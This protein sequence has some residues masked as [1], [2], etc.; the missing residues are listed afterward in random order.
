MKALPIVFLFCFLSILENWNVEG[1]KGMKIKC[2][3]L[4]RG[5]FG[6]RYIKLIINPMFLRSTDVISR[7]Y[8]CNPGTRCFFC[9]FLIAFHLGNWNPDS[10]P[11]KE[12]FIGMFD[13]IKEKLESDP[14]YFSKET[15]LGFFQDTLA[16]LK[17]D[18]EHCKDYQETT[19][20]YEYIEQAS[21]R[22]GA[23]VGNST[24]T[25]VT[26]ALGEITNTLELLEKIPKAMSVPR[27][28]FSIISLNIWRSLT[29][30]LG[31]HL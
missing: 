24:S 14:Q 23:I 13:D 2:C 22:L 8:K 29:I 12:P 21:S 9:T 25:F 17:E 7:C 10:I 5:H 15:I 30:I 1:R 11:F 6:L 31:L 3:R 4:A 18:C 19:K 28:V 16:G 27:K 20:F 26:A